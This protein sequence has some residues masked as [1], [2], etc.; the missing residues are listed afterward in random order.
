VRGI[1][2]G[3]RRADMEPIWEVTNAPHIYLS[4]ISF[5]KKQH[6]GH[7]HCSPSCDLW[8]QEIWSRKR[9]WSI[10]LRVAAIRMSRWGRI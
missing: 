3:R 2:L 5:A 1:M 7:R 8:V 6:G 10:I 9:W 4:Y